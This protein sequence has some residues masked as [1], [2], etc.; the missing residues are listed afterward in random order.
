M[1]LHLEDEVLR[2]VDEAA[3]EL[4]LPRETPPYSELRSLYRIAYSFPGQQRK[5]LPDMQPVARHFADI[6]AVR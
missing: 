3:R 2:E 1:S 5:P 6:E 4:H